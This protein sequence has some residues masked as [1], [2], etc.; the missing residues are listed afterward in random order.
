MQP[1]SQEV[2]DT[3]L[4]LVTHENHRKLAE[5]LMDGVALDEIK[6]HGF[7]DIQIT[8]YQSLIESVVDGRTPLRDTPSPEEATPS[9]VTPNEVATEE[10]AGQETAPE[11]VA[12]TEPEVPTETEQTTPETVTPET[13][14]P[15]TVSETPSEEV[16]SAP[17]T[18]EDTTPSTE[19]GEIPA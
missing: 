12:T 4:S 13:V 16:P 9:E 1:Y 6:T 15:E 19:G 11:E 3:V 8:Q 14:T 2:R 7:D 17:Q 5:M 10:N 18:E